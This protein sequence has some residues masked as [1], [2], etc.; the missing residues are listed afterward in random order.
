LG[1]LA[2]DLLLYYTFCAIVFI[3]VYS[4]PARTF[5][6]YFEAVVGLSL[7]L[8][9]SGPAL[10]HSSY[11]LESLFKNEF[12]CFGSLFA[13]RAFLGIVFFEC[14]TSLTLLESQGVQA[15]SL[16]NSILKWVFPILPEYCV[17]RTFYDIVQTNLS[18]TQLSIGNF[19]EE[20]SILPYLVFAFIDSVLY[21]GVFWV[22]CRGFACPTK[23]SPKAICPSAKEA[24]AH[25]LVRVADLAFDY[26]RNKEGENG[27]RDLNFSV[28]EK[29][30]LGFIGPCGAGK[31]TL[32]KLLAGVLK[33]HRGEI[34]RLEKR[35]RS[36]I[37]GYCPQSGGLFPSMTAREHM[38][39]YCNLW[40]LAGQGQAHKGNRDERYLSMLGLDRYRNNRVHTL[41][42]GNRKKL[43]V[44]LALCSSS[45]IAVLDEPSFG[46]D[47]EGQMLLCNCIR[48]AAKHKS[49]V[50]SSH[51]MSECEALC[52]RIGIMQNGRLASLQTMKALQ[53]H[54]KE[55]LR[56]EMKPKFDFQE[57]VKNFVAR[58]FPNALLVEEDK[59][60]SDWL[61]YEVQADKMNSKRQFGSTFY[62]VNKLHEHGAIHDF[63]LSEMGIEDFLILGE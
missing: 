34:L 22:L 60:G 39:F 3:L 27:L 50:I 48:K 37:T 44:A 24:D 45:P 61:K 32:L 25:K 21:S 19:S 28:Y 1:Q 20:R 55:A 6:W 56:L 12:L 18:G 17:A 58:H 9:C 13:S 8:F 57:S 14:G 35:K 30:V 29:G 54:Y 10:L 46:V 47:P 59:S 16:A 5:F 41:S 7:V 23:A 40:S 62:K 53:R 38:H 31:S 49:V 42:E 43:S 51:S 26:Y 63:R 11:L 2:F 33:A 36:L 52:T 4:F 15:A